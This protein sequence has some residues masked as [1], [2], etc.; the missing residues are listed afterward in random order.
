MDDDDPLFVTAFD[1][2]ANLIILGKLHLALAS[3]AQLKNAIAVGD[4]VVNAI[5]RGGEVL[6]PPMTARAPDTLAA[7]LI[8]QLR[9]G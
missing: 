3:P 7:D 2:T 6:Y 1:P 5:R 4:P 8:A 9:L